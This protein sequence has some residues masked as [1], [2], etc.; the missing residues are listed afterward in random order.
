M[1]F[2]FEM[3][4][5][6]KKWITSILVSGMLLWLVIQYLA[7]IYLVNGSSMEPNFNQGDVILVTPIKSP[8]FGNI[9]KFDPVLITNQTKGKSKSIK[10]IIGMPGDTLRIRDFKNIDSDYKPLKKPYW[11]KTNTST[12]NWLRKG[13]H[14]AAPMSTA[15][16]W[17]IGLTTDERKQLLKDKAIKWATS[18][19]AFAIENAPFISQSPHWTIAQFGPL[20]IP[21]RASLLRITKQNLMFYKTILINEH[22]SSNDSLLQ[23]VTKNGQLNYQPIQDYYFVMGDNRGISVDSR[24]YG[25]V[26]K[27]QIKGRVVSK[28]F[29][30]NSLKI[31]EP[32]TER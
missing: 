23:L 14:T 7:A 32:L 4:A 12:Y 31:R 16:D 24:F 20:A 22:P 30:N 10:R 5:M 27:G 21:T 26:E 15:N 13:I 25:F 11:V 1:Y 18:P 6:I 17:L 19:P 9:S 8:W 28:L 2:R 3:L 29:S